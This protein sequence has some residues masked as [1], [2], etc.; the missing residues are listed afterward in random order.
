MFLFSFI[1]SNT[2]R[3]HESPSYVYY[4]TFNFSLTFLHFMRLSI[5]IIVPLVSNDAD[6]LRRILLS[7]VSHVHT[8]CVVTSQHVGDLCIEYEMV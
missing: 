3:Y 5:F 1:S 7:L 4:V 2:R 8:T 6:A